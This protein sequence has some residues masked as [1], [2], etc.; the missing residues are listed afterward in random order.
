MSTQHDQLVLPLTPPP[1]AAAGGLADSFITGASNAD[2][3]EAMQNWRTWPNRMLCLYG[4]AGAGKSHLARLWAQS[5]GA[6][7]LD[8][9]TLSPNQIF[10]KQDLQAELASR[11]ALVIDHADRCAND[12]ALFHLF[13]I[14]VESGHYLLFLAA[15]PP[16]QWPVGLADLASRAASL[17]TAKLDRPDDDVLQH[18]VRKLFAERQLHCAE[19]VITYLVPRMQRSGDFAQ[20]LVQTL[21]D[22]SMVTKRTISRKLAS[23]ALDRLAAQAAPDTRADRPS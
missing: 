4:P 19:D 11:T 7:L 14:A 22:L 1:S 15:K 17:A 20:N 21:D 13:N 5:A 6:E 18:L 12:Q 10:T 2:A 8:A 16:A 23:E 9:A 3:F